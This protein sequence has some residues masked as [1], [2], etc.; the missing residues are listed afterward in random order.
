MLQY[1]LAHS[2]LQFVLLLYAKLLESK[3]GEWGSKIGNLRF[4]KL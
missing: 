4:I 3:M 2:I 1:N